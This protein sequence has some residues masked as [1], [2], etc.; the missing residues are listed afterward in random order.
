M[1]G[2]A[3][4]KRHDKHGLIDFS[5]D[6]VID[7]KH[8]FIK[9]LDWGRAAVKYKNLVK[10]FSVDV[11]KIG[12]KVYQ[13]LRPGIQ[14][15]CIY[16]LKKGDGIIDQYENIIFQSDGNS[17]SKLEDFYLVKSE[18]GKYGLLNSSAKRILELKYDSIEQVES[19]VF[20]LK[21]EDKIEVMD[22]LKMELI[23]SGTFLIYDLSRAL[24]Y[25][26]AYPKSL[27]FFMMTST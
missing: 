20:I 25:S 2:Y 16:T 24:S 14:D 19:S 18:D 15:R 10:Y 13:E 17:I 5:F 1:N 11:G 26:P 23:H 12:G 9:N 3:V 21:Q 27:F 6:Q 8:P 7:L 4:V 22:V